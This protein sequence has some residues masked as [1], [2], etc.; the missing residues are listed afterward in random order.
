MVVGV[1]VLFVVVVVVVV[2]VFGGMTLRGDSS[3][4]CHWRRRRN[5]TWRET[6]RSLLAFQSCVVVY[7]LSVSIRV[8]W[9]GVVG[10]LRK[11]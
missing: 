6:G 8:N 11:I 10:G 5:W 3:E 2:V 1:V 7:G 9:R 4:R